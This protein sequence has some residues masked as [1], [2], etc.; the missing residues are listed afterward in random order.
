M[1]VD[2]RSELERDLSVLESWVPTAFDRLTSAADISSN[3]SAEQLAAQMQ[4]L[5][6]SCFLCI[7]C[8]YGLV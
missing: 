4:L 2:Q 3:K 8:F 7:S 6:V 5:L 1:S